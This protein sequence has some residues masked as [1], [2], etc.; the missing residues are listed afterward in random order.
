M[1]IYTDY[2]LR[3]LLSV[4]SFYHKRY[5]FYNK[6]L[7]VARKP[8]ISHYLDSFVGLL[9]CAVTNLLLPQPTTFLIFCTLVGF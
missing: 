1:K 8:T 6:T 7:P 3:L 5:K 9:L 4:N 2:I